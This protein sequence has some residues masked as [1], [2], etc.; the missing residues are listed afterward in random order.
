MESLI[1]IDVGNYKANAS[2]NEWCLSVYATCM[3]VGGVVDMERY[4]FE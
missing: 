2:R 3:C 1:E 4:N